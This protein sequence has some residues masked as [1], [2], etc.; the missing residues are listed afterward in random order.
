[1]AVAESIGAPL[2]RLLWSFM[3][4]RGGELCCLTACGRALASVHAMSVVAERSIEKWVI[5]ERRGAWDDLVSRLTIPELSQ[6][7]FEA[8]CLAQGNLMT[9]QVLFLQRLQKAPAMTEAFALGMLAK[10][11]AWM[12]KLPSVQPT[13]PLM[14]IKMLFL[15]AEVTNFVVVTLADVLPSAHKKQMLREL[16]N[17]MLCVGNARRQHGL[18]K[19][20][21]GMGLGGGS[22]TYSVECHVASLAIGVYLRLQTRTGAPLRVDDRIPYKLT[23]TTEKH[24]KSLEQLLA[25]KHCFQLQKRMEWIVAFLKSPSRSLA[26]QDE[27]FV[28]LFSRM[29]PTHPWMLAKCIRG[30]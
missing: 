20:I 24:L 26:D 27:F 10:L 6:D 19:A 16:C 7:E 15:A 1:M 29:Y 4:F 2:G 12:E 11:M 14:E 21:A 3:G 5:E 22:L 28:S 18:M 23:R 30:A 9:L 8:A 17:I 13:T 25:S